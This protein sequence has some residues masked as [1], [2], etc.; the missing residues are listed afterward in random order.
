MQQLPSQYPMS[1]NRPELE[2]ITRKNL[3]FPKARKFYDKTVK[4][5]KE[6]N[7]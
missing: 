5:K 2:E 4:L 7:G 3:L 6:Q 1:R